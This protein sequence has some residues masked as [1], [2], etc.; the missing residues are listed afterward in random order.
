MRELKY[1]ERKLLKKTDFLHWRSEKDDREGGVMRRYHIQNRDDYKKYNLVVGL[2]TKLAHALR[3]FSPN[4]AF[5]A[6]MT[7]LLLSRLYDLGAIPSKKNLEQCEKL[8][9]SA[10]CRRRLPVVMCR[11]KFTETMREAV[12]FVEQGHIRIGPHT[13]TDPAFMVTRR[14]EDFI[15]WVDDS[16]IRRKILKYNDKLDDFDLL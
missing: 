16:K 1:H 12:T 5:R 15:T 6:E 10:L 13:I 2:V 7:E 11:L 9:V 14:N 8:S 3:R 4:D